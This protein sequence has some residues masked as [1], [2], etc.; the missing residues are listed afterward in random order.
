[1]NADIKAKWT[2]ALRSGKYKQGAGSLCRR[3]ADEPD[4]WRFCCMGVLC[5]VMDVKYQEAEWEGNGKSVE[6]CY[7]DGIT[8]MRPD[9]LPDSVVEDAELPSHDPVLTYSDGMDYFMS[10]LNDDMELSFGEIADMIDAQL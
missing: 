6:R 2:A 5:D 7:G 4:G 9:V 1:M 8:L 3:H 10:E